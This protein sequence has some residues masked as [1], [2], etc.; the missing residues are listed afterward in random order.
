MD[1]INV[2]SRH[3][4]SQI[5][6]TEAKESFNDWICTG[7]QAR[8][9]CTF[10]TFWQK[11]FF[12]VF[13]CLNFLLSK[14]TFCDY[15]P[16]KFSEWACFMQNIPNRSQRTFK[17]LKIC[18]RT[19]SYAVHFVIKNNFSVI[20]DPSKCSKLTRSIKN[21]ANRSQRFF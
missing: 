9:P 21:I 18:W 7:V 17:R 13:T 8:T 16:S 12:C 14:T 6:Q 4:L 1:P 2:L 5:Y 15:G 20:I 11:R 10:L 19:S 3:V